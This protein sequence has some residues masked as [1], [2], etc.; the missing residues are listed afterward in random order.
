MYVLIGGEDF[1]V[2]GGG[3]GGSMFGEIFLVLLR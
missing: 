3:C 2:L 1:F